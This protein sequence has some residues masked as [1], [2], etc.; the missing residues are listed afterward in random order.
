MKFVYS[1]YPIEK[2]KIKNKIIVKWVKMGFN[3]I[4]TENKNASTVSKLL[5]SKQLTMHK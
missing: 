3:T 2:I 5:Y 1:F 4:I